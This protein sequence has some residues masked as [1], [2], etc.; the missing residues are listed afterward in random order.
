MKSDGPIT[1]KVREQPQTGLQEIW[2]EGKLAA[3]IHDVQETLMD[4][5][6]FARF[7]PY[8]KE[9]RSILKPDPDGGAYTY[10]RVELPWVSSRDYVT[11]TWI[12]S[13]VG[14]DG[15]GV[16]RNKWAATPDRLPHRHGI[17]RLKVNDG[18]WEVKRQGKQSQANLRF[19][20]DPGGWIPAAA[21]NFGS[22]SGVA[23]T[24]EAVEKEA[25]RRGEERRKHNGGQATQTTGSR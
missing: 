6:S 19:V 11:K 3:D 25:K 5:V 8:V 24:F 23:G 4:G 18:S 1:I 7:M 17:I 13:R 20:V 15:S 16:F 9:S 10:T 21:A 22:T 12:L 14:E 2:A